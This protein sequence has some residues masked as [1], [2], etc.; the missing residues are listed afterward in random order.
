MT[1]TNCALSVEKQL[2]RSGLKN[3]EVN[4]I[5]GEA[6]FENDEKIP[7]ATLSKE[8]GAIGYEV[9]TAENPSVRRFSFSLKQKLLISAIFTAPLLLHMVLPHSSLFH[10]PWFQFAL[11]LPVYLIGFMHFGRSAWGSLKGGVPNMDVLIFIGS[12]AAFFYSLI[13][14]T[15]YS[16]LAHNY[17]FYETAATIITLVLLGN[18]IEEKA[19]AKTSESTK[20]LHDMQP[21]VV[22]ALVNGQWQ[23]VALKDIS[24]G[25]LV[26]LREGDYVPVDGV[27]HENRATLDMRFLSG[28]S[29]LVEV[30]EGANVKSGSLV[31]EGNMVIQATKAAAQSTLSEIIRS[32]ESAQSDKPAIQRLGDRISAVFVPVVVGIALITF[33]LSHFAFQVALDQALMRAIAVLVISCPC[34]MGLAAPTAIIVGFGR[35][36]K[37]GILLRKGSALETLAQAE[38]FVFDKT[39]TLTSEN[40]QVASATSI[41]GDSELNLSIAKAMSAISSHPV[42]RAIQ[43]Y[44]EESNPLSLQEIQEKKG[45]GISAMDAEGSVYFLGKSTSSALVELTKNGDVLCQFEIEEEIKPGA[46]ALIHHLKKNGKCVVMLSGDHEERCRKV[47]LALGIDE[48]FSG[49]TPFDKIE[50]VRGWAKSQKVVMAGDGINDAAALAQAHV[51]ISMSGATGIAQQNAQVILMH[52]QDMNLLLK[53][54]SVGKHTMQ[55]IRQNFFWAFAYNA[56]AI[57]IAAMGFLSPMVAALSMAF[58]DVVVVGNSLRLRWKKIF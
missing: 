4:F 53:A 49:Q 22:I 14:T 7:I 48:Y 1:C 43:N 51:A 8:L 35:A 28:E 21:K 9:I 32:I 46:K 18:F 34:A 40:M 25:D 23:N 56:V 30:K 33:L 13:G 26:R 2:L 45:S 5:R 11:A 31:V 37:N 27:V 12:T 57:P 41:S 54:L 58:S 42:S 3:V 17:L 10:H 20:E 6:S 29:E 52:N 55:T 19:V 15:V 39:G 16:E 50:K 44:L 36:A 47:A 24:I 38:L